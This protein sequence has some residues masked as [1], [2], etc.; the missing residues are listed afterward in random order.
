MICSIRCKWTMRSLSPTNRLSSKAL[1]T[2]QRNPEQ[3]TKEREK[4]KV[5][6]MTPLWKS[7]TE[8]RFKFL[9][10]RSLFSNSPELCTKPYKMANSTLK[11]ILLTIKRF[12]WSFKIQFRFQTKSIFTL[13]VKWSGLSLNHKINMVIARNYL[14][15]LKVNY[16]SIQLDD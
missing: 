13:W 7:W 11:T 1:V 4:Q 10:Q 15:F 8:C 12:W 6:R 16:S 9:D 5:N 2:Y 14:G 3:T